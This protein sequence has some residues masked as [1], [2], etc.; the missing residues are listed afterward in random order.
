MDHG[1]TLSRVEP[2]EGSHGVEEIG[3]IGNGGRGELREVN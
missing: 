2:L 3:L 1:S